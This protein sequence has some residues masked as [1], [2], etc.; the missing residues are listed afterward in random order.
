MRPGAAPPARPGPRRAA[1][2]PTI[3]A[4]RAD[5]GGRRTPLAHC[6]AGWTPS[7]LTDAS[8]VGATSGTMRGHNPF[9]V[10]QKHALFGRSS[11]GI[12][13]VTDTVG[14]F[15]PTVVWPEARQAE[16]RGGEPAVSGRPRRIPNSIR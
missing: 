5:G 7:E 16:A 4:A 2:S 15:S 8:R 9:S 14:E 13:I 3:I 10:P 11:D 1:I 12:I 6:L